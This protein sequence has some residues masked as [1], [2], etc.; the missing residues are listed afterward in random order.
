MA[1]TVKFKNGV[2]TTHSHDY[3]EELV[4]GDSLVKD[5]NSVTGEYLEKVLN[6][7]LNNKVNVA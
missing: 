4:I 6:K 3:F 1:N 5:K 2:T 7:D